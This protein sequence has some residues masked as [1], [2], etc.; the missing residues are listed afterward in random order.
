MYHV[1]P[2]R[3]RSQAE[4]FQFITLPHD[5]NPSEEL[6]GRISTTRKVL[7]PGDSTKDGLRVGGASEVLRDAK[8]AIYL[9]WSNHIHRLAF[10]STKQSVTVQRFVRKLR[11]SMDPMRYTCLVWPAQMDAY[12]SASALF[13]YPVCSYSFAMIQRLTLERRSQAQLQLPRSADRRR[14]GGLDI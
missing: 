13:K 10:D 14:R 1:P 6:D 8:G 5:H 12:Q 3:P 2:E 7:L 9:L 4:N 11:Y